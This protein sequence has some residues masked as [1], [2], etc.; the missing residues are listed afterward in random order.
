[1]RNPETLPG[2]VCAL[3][4]VQPPRRHHALQLRL[5]ALSILSARGE[6]PRHGH[7]LVAHGGALHRGGVHHA[8]EQV[9]GPATPRA[10]R[11]VEGLD[12]VH[13]PAV[14]LPAR[15]RGVQR[16]PRHDH[17]L[18]VDDR[19]R[20]L[21]LLLH[22]GRLQRRACA[23]DALAPQLPRR[24]P[25]ARARQHVHPLLHLPAAH[26]LLP[27]DLRRH[28]RRPRAEPHQVGHPR[29]D[30][31]RRR[32]HLPCL[33]YAARALRRALWL[34]GRDAEDGRHR[35]HP[36]RVVLPHLAGPLQ[37]HPRHGVRAQLPRDQGL[38][39]QQRRAAGAAEGGRHRRRQRRRPRRASVLVCR[40]LYAPE[41][42][43]QRHERVHGARGP[44]LLHLP[45]QRAACDAQLPLGAAAR[46]WQDDARDVP[47]AA[48]PLAH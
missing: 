9:D 38:L 31:G 27:H 6:E 34:G 47:A 42:A 30:H 11:G 8:Q 5:R 33:G 4:G 36:L 43:L 28:A 37:H 15:R 39:R 22:Q 18:R 10:D 29:Q 24:P 1:M 21:Q 44:A 13:V 48:P 17:V 26:L 40:V 7:V 20:E 32:H 23:A 16:H 19:V 45:A 12:A 3:A 14:P 2:R 41:G 46:H 35:R 25:H